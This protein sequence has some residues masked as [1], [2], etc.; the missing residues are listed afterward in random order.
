[1]YLMVPFEI[2][3]DRPKKLKIYNFLNWVS[4]ILIFSSCIGTRNLPEDKYL[5][6]RQKLKG[7]KNLDT[8]ELVELYQQKP[9]R[10]VLKVLP[11]SLYTWMYQV[12]ER[13]FDAEKINRKKDKIT[14]K[15]DRKIAAN[16]GNDRKTASLESRKQA[17]L[18]KKDEIIQNGNKFMQWGEPLAVYDSTLAQAT[19]DKF[20]QYIYSKGYFLGEVSHTVKYTGKRASATYTINEGQPYVFDSLISVVSDS[21]ITRLLSES[22]SD[23]RIQEGNS[24]DTQELE[25]EIIRIENL[26]KDNGYYEFSRQFVEFAV[27]TA[28]LGDRKVAVKT[29]VNLPSK[30]GYHKVFE[31]DSVIFTTDANVPSPRTQRQSKYFNRITYRFF[32]EKYAKKILDRRLFIYPGDLYSKSKTFNTQRQL[33]NLDMFKFVNIN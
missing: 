27:D 16:A 15:F 26:L 13:S 4:L 18:A 20:T 7:A 5:L 22:Q 6:D 29:I 32:E 1:M 12:G 10:K 17:R 24:Y 11:I 3:F 14:K 31:V 21:S 30:R 25:A 19:V 28:I 2:I 33:A 23:S 9:N 8:E